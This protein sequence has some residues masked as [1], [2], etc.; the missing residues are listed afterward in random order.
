MI[1]FSIGTGC[2]DDKVWFAAPCS[3]EQALQWLKIKKFN[4][5]N[6][7]GIPEYKNARGITLRPSSKSASII[8]LKKWEPSNPDSL[9]ILVHECV[10]A[11]QF[12]LS[13]SG[14][15]DSSGESLCYLTHYIF[16]AILKRANKINEPTER[17][18]D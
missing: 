15:E 5:W 6:D 16:R 12:I 3:H 11:A 7:D 9:C 18:K 14:V 8:L 13:A 10:H 1:S 2:Y 4:D 17:R